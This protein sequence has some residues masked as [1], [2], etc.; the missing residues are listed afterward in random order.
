MAREL[1]AEFACV[2]YDSEEK[3][4]YAARDPIGIRPLFYGY[5]TQGQICFASEM[6]IL[7]TTC[8]EVH[9][10]PPGH[11]YVE[12]GLFA[13]SDPAE[14]GTN[15]KEDQEVILSGIKELFTQ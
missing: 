5:D 15:H 12:G 2:I 8:H 11:G 4:Y 13:Y 10:F 14:G 1:D 9:P 3:K 7:H 6:R